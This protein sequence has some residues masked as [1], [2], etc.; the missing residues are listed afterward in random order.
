MIDNRRIS[1][2]GAAAKLI[3]IVIFAGLNAFGPIDSPRASESNA[4]PVPT[5]TIYPGD[6]IKDNWLV[7]RDFASTSPARGNVVASRDVVVG[8]IAR[9]TLLPGTPIP[10]NAVSDPKIVSNGAKVR[11]VFEE[12]GLTIVTYG[13]ALQDG[14]VGE[15]ISLR[16]LETGITISGTVQSDGSVRLSGG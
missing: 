13:A 14:G 15:L 10:L 8:K 4:L 11:I 5:I 3:G 16:N 12:L 1:G 2:P 7:D 6:V 9:R